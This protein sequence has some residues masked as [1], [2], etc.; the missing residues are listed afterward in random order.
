MAK[1]VALVFDLDDT[2]ISSRSGIIST[3]E[4]VAKEIN[5]VIDPEIKNK[6][7]SYKTMNNKTNIK[8]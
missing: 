4:T 8:Q 3:L 7:N 2:L 1:L 6:L 5:I